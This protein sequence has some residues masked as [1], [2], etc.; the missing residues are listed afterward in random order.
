LG[1]ANHGIRPFNVPYGQR[2]QQGQGGNDN[3]VGSPAR[4]KGPPAQFFSTNPDEHGRE[5]DRERAPAG[6]WRDSPATSDVRRKEPM[7]NVQD[8]RFNEED[9]EG[10]NN[11]PHKAQHQQQQERRVDPVRA[12]KPIKALKQDKSQ[13]EREGRDSNTNGTGQGEDMAERDAGDGEGERPALGG[14]QEGGEGSF[15]PSFPSDIKVRDRDREDHSA[16]STSTSNQRASFSH[17]AE[18]DEHEQH[19]NINTN[20][21][22][23]G[24]EGS[25]TRPP[26][27]ANC[28]YFSKGHC[29]F[30]SKCH[31]IHAGVGG[32]K[33]SSNMPNNQERDARDGE[34][35]E[36]GRGE[37]IDKGNRA[38]PGRGKDRGVGG[39]EGNNSGRGRGGRGPKKQNNNA[40]GSSNDEGASMSTPASVPVSASPSVSENA[41][42]PVATK[43][44]SSTGASHDHVA[45]NSTAES[46]S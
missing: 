4:R 36:G 34:E 39:R 6:S 3:D 17:V 11:G 18:G 23:V 1:A 8:R 38:L 40:P 46:S 10:R 19:S 37:R 30:G 21:S 32:A 27:S 42:A 43:D 2:D 28:R 13:V 7:R 44:S 12:K 24:L 16:Q 33:V 31:F 41:P 29:V 20:T 35:G 14:N 22:S 5:R 25:E 45:Q 9:N 15:P 26:P